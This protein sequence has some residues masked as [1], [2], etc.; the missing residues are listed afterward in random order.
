MD[1]SV[2]YV[3]AWADKKLLMKATVYNVFQMQRVTEFQE[4][5]SIGSASSNTF[6]PNF[7]NNLNYQ[8]PRSIELSA[9]YEF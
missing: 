6:N 3:P 9:R 8:T 5:S 7:L 2:T 4:T 1:A